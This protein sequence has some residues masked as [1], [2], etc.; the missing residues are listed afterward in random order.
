MSL[1]SIFISEHN[2]CESEAKNLRFT[3]GEQM[4]VPTSFLDKKVIDGFD[5]ILLTEINF[6]S[7]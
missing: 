6:V 5:I 2:L 1:F 7:I 3:L 4:D